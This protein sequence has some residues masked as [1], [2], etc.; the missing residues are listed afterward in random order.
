M[1]AAGRGPRARRS[2]SDASRLDLVGKR[3]RA[4]LVTLCEADQ[5]GSRLRLLPIERSASPT[6]CN[7]QG[8]LQPSATGQP[9]QRP[10]ELS[11]PFVQVRALTGQLDTWDTAVRQCAAGPGGTLDSGQWVE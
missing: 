4:R 3:L 9:G 7:T 10:F 1:G 2:V 6:G 11:G 5:I 8:V